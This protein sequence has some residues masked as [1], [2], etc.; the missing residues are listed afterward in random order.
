[1]KSVDA[2]DNGEVLEKLALNEYHTFWGCNSVIRESS[3]R[4]NET[5]SIGSLSPHRQAGHEFSMKHC[6][7]YVTLRTMKLL[8]VYIS[9]TSLITRKQRQFMRF[10]F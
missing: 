10:R 4:H 5:N 3:L 8:M 7:P 6:L 2:I 1:M 9:K